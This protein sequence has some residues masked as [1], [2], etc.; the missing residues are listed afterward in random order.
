MFFKSLLQASA[1]LPLFYTSA[2]AQ[3]A[4]NNSPSLC[5]KAYNN[6]THL[7]A[8]DAAFLRDSTTSFSTSGNQYYNA[9]VALDAGVRLL[10][11]QVHKLNNT[12][13][14]EAWHLCHSSCD[15]LDAGTLEK[16]LA[17]IKTWMDNNSNDV[18]T[19]LLVNS[20]NA[21][22]SDL[23]AQFQA[24]GIDKYAYAP[25]NG[26]SIPTTWPTL[27]S[28]ISNNTRLM[29]F[30]ASLSTPSSDYPYLMVSSNLSPIS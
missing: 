6:I 14:D 22:P 11:A 1:L 17:S 24:S 26:S 18:V 8:H 2:S 20:D 16:W 4:C 21:S 19:I 10:S 3:T 25:T 15:L 30:V 9:T 28:L 27:Q 7:G 13:G 23:G 5:N 12:S 29:T